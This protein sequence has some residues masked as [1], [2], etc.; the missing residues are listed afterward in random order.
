MYIYVVANNIL[1][2]N[3]NKHLVL[4]KKILEQ[5][6]NLVMQGN[7]L[8]KLTLVNKERTK[9]YHSRYETVE[10]CDNCCLGHY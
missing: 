3:I 1:S 5:L 9:H 2:A 7:M 8:K 6:L 10:I 4:L